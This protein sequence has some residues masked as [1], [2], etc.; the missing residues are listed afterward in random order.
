[1]I[2]YKILKEEN[3]LLKEIIER[4]T[5]TMRKASEIYGQAIKRKDKLINELV[6]EGA[7]QRLIDRIKEI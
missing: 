1:M 6:S 4:Q 7:D 3:Q 5:K 2:S